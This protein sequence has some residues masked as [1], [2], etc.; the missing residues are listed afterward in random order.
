MP[1]SRVSSAD[2]G[3]ER[4]K[5]RRPTNISLPEALTAAARSLGINLSQACERGLALEVAEARARLWLK[6]NR[7]AMDS[8]NEYVDAHGLP[9]ANLRQF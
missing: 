2:P 4:P 5:L 7:Q 9:L 6:E 1:P 3:S 8:S